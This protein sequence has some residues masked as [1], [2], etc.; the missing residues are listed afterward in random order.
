MAP[1]PSR[2]DLI[3]I[4]I[5][6]L[7]GWGGGSS[8]LTFETPTVYGEEPSLITGSGA[9]A[10]GKTGSY[11]GHGG[12]T[13]GLDGSGS[14]GACGG[15]VT[16]GG[17]AGNINAQTGLYKKGGRGY[18]NWGTTITP[19]ENYGGGGGAGL[20]G[21]GGGGLFSAGGGGSSSLRYF[22]IPGFFE[23]NGIYCFDGT[24]LGPGNRC[25]PFFTFNYDPGLGANRIGR[26]LNGITFETPYHGA[27]SQVVE[28][29]RTKW[30]PCSES[31]LD[32]QQD[33]TGKIDYKTHI[34]L[35]EEQY[36][37]IIASLPSVPPPSDLFGIRLS[38]E[39]NG[40]RSGNK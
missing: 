1:D 31:Q 13:Q 14:F 28:Y 39:I 37:T 17:T 38:F 27:N 8:I 30:C 7:A 22:L 21:G 34:C 12:V 25:N 6:H 10:G 35:T 20:W 5:Y 33:T 19:S 29:H 23:L 32:F 11:G 18:A 15:S 40:N 16:A 36:Q 3:F 2:E 26:E 4:P 9:G 24:D